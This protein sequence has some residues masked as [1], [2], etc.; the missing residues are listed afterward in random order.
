[1]CFLDLGYH[2]AYYFF[3]ESIKLVWFIL[4]NSTFIMKI[5]VP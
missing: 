2:F 1:M 5:K 4:T 3:S